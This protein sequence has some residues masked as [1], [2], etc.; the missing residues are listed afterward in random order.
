ME[1]KLTN[2]LW[3]YLCS[4]LLIKSS[5]ANRNGLLKFKIMN[6]SID[7]NDRKLK[8]L[9]WI[10]FKIIYSDLTYELEWNNTFLH[11]N[12]LNNHSQ[13]LLMNFWMP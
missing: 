4:C 9:S 1:C 5:Y 12:F 11:E 2:L 10:L 8:G 6:W 13:F 3:R 7:W